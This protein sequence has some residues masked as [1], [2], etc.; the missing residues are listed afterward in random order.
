MLDLDYNKL[1]LGLKTMS[2]H[3]HLVSKLEV[4]RD[5]ARV[6]IRIL[7]M[8]ESGI[9]HFYTRLCCFRFYLAALNV[10]W[11]VRVQL[12]LI[13]LSSYSWK[14]Y[15]DLLTPCNKPLPLSLDELGY[16]ALNAGI[17]LGKVQLN[18]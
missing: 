4:S 3:A 7:Y 9:I 8:Y 17:F 12:N 5:F 14:K 2:F 16:L 6:W 13:S 10:S 15:I 18:I 1:I 11:H